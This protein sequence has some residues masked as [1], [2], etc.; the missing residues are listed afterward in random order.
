[1]SSRLG[2]L[3]NPS[4]PRPFRAPCYIPHP[5]PPTLWT[6]SPLFGW[7]VCVGRFP[8]AVSCSNRIT[9][10]RPGRRTGALGSTTGILSFRAQPTTPPFSRQAPLCHDSLAPHLGSVNGLGPRVDWSAAKIAVPG[11]GWCKLHAGIT[12]RAAARN[13]QLVFFH[14]N[15]WLKEVAGISAGQSSTGSRLGRWRTINSWAVG[16]MPDLRAV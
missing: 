9:M 8:T 3:P 10:L 7:R 12:H 6:L 1:M 16:V 4:C 2:V 5:P 13:K 11:G 15:P 14:S